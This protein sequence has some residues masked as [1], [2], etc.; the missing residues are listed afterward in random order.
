LAFD[1]SPESLL[2]AIDVLL[3]GGVGVGVLVT[4]R[5]SAVQ[6]G[7][8]GSAFALLDRSIQSHYPG[9]PAGFTWG[10]AFVWLKGKGVQADWKKLQSCLSEYEAHR[11][12]DKPL[13]GGGCEKDIAALA[14]KIGGS[15]SGDRAKA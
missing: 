13:V 10:E 5:L 11:Y 2:L 15:R 14:M 12:G 7:D 4:R 3:L 8:V 6:A 1:V 9:L